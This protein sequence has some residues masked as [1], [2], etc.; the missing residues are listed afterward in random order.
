MAEGADTGAEAVTAMPGACP[1]PQVLQE[2]Q[3]VAD[4]AFQKEDV[5]SNGALLRGGL[6]LSLV[7]SLA[8]DQ[9]LRLSN[10]NAIQIGSE[11]RIQEERLHSK[12]QK[13]LCN[14]QLFKDGRS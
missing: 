14:F 4:S 3:V 5:F 12:K 7:P 10:K 13:Y 9:E 6:V 11:K 1:W 2:G 8:L